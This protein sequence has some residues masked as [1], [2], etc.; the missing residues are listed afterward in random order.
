[1]KKIKLILLLLTLTAV[2]GCL[3]K[4]EGKGYLT[5][6]C[7]LSENLDNIIKNEEINITHKDDD[8]TLITIK[9]TYLDSSDDKML[10]ILKDSILSE[11]QSLKNEK[12]LTIEVIDK[13]NSLEINYSFDYNNISENVKQL[14]KIDNKYH[15]Q[16]KYLKEQGYI[17][18]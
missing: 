3:L 1:M 9:I 14:Y 16:I 5:K 18:K 6:T 15:I 8:M 17:C 12:G 7:S 2:T 13:D 11:K 10:S 4:E